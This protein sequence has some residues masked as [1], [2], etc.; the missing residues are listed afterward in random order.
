MF[1]QIEEIRVWF[2]KQ[3]LEQIVEACGGGRICYIKPDAYAMRCRHIKP[4]RKK[5][6][7]RW[8]AD[9]SASRNYLLYMTSDTK[10]RQLSDK[11]LCKCHWATLCAIDRATSA[12]RQKLAKKK[13]IKESNFGHKRR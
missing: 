7:R 10:S 1:F 12:K 2:R 9:R 6:K 5:E 13:L 4:K 8:K 11:C 3:G